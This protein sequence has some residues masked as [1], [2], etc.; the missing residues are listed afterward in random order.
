MRLSI[1]IPT[2]N[3][4]DYIEETLKSLLNQEANPYEIVVS[5]NYSNDGTIDILNK[6]SSNIR[7]IK[8][9]KFL[10]MMEN[11]NFLVSNLKGDWF[12]LLSSDDI[13]KPNFTR[14]LL[15]GIK[16]NNTSVLVRAGYEVID[17]SGNIVQ[18]RKILTAKPITCPSDNFK[19]QLGGPKTSFAAFAAS[20]K[21]WDEVGGFPEKLK[22]HGDWGFWLKLTPLGDFTYVS[23]IISQYRVYKR[24]DIRV[25]R[26]RYMIE[27]ELII[28]NDIIKPL[29]YFHRVPEKEYLPQLRGRFKNILITLQKN[30]FYESNGDS[31]SKLNEIS[32]ITNSMKELKMYLN[33]EKIEKFSIKKEFRGFISKF[34]HKVLS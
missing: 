26:L 2:Y 22:I 1:G 8:P 9:P 4:A 11:W 31:F 29:A 25:E 3:Q 15:D 14:D 30:N 6:Y 10:S 21:A 19:E 24:E 12:S 27:D 13:A 7:I 32:T 23:A 18:K 28:I 17:K 34:G 20:R 16:K 33:E 5:D